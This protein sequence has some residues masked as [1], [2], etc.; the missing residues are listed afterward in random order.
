MEIFG[1]IYLFDGA[2]FIFQCLLGYSNDSAEVA[3][4]SKIGEWKQVKENWVSE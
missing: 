3:A 2:F 4:E 1:T